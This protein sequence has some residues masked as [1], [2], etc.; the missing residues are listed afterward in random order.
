MYILH[1]A[2]VRIS[3]ATLLL[4]PLLRGKRKRQ[5]SQAAAIFVK[6]CQLTPWHTS[7]SCPLMAI[8]SN[9]GHRPINS[10]QALPNRFCFEIC[11][12]LCIGVLLQDQA[13]SVHCLLAAW[14]MCWL[15]TMPATAI[16]GSHLP[17]NAS[18]KYIAC[19]TLDLASVQQGLAK[20]SGVFAHCLC[21]TV[22][23]PYV[24]V[25]VSETWSPSCTAGH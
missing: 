1:N 8:L 25:T 10:R 23:L 18:T 19:F 5:P 11:F 24:Q 7:A 20:S 2:V 3:C 15:S 22:Y 4:P 14:F 12:A 21:T 16:P 13:F 17:G 9:T 6:R